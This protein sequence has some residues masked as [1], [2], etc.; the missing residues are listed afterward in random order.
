MNAE[1]VVQK[2][3]S[4]AKAEAEKIVNDAKSKAD[5]QALDLDNEIRDFDAQT[6]QL[7]KEAAEDK[8]QRMMANARMANAKQLL[9]AKVELLDEVFE[10]AKAAV[11][12]LP[13]DAYLA[14][15]TELM[16]R[17][18]QTGDEE[19]IV[20]KDEKRINESFISKLNKELG[21]GFKGNLRLAGQRA[22]ITG[23]FIL[24]HGKVQIN[25]G[26]DVLIE[27]LRDTME[28]ELAQVLFENDG[29]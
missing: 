24:A 28:T 5:E 12:Q 2:I 13:D 27:S 21:S 3:L 17:S 6:H 29:Q 10:K 7:S 16:K 14:L 25:A 15:I 22:D 26:T 20:G 18:V 11:Q 19:V 1:Q 23:G 9:A 8:L 4:E